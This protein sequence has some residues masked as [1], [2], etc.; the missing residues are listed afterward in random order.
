M[1]ANTGTYMA[2]GIISIF[3]RTPMALPKA[4]IDR[5]PTRNLIAFM[6]SSFFRNILATESFKFLL[7]VKYREMEKNNATPRMMHPKIGICGITS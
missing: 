6:D 3:C 2:L 4:K 7:A 5:P 1:E